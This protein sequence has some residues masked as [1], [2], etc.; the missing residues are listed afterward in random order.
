VGDEGEEVIKEH[1]E[2]VSE[3]IERLKETYPELMEQTL[4]NCIPKLSHK[5]F[6]YASLTS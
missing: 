3:E 1:I 6:I 4:L 2:K 5:G